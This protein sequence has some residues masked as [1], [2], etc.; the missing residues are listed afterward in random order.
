MTIDSRDLSPMLDIRHRA[1]LE[2]ID[3][4][5]SYLKKISQLSF[6]A[7]TLETNGGRQPQRYALLTED[8]CYFLL[9]LMRNNDRVAAAKLMLAK[10]FFDVR[11]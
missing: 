5:S 8:Q 3:K 2:N 1:I 11:C 7:G 4:Y 10:L 6:K 9:T